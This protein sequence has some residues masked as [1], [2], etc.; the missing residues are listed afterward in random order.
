M[1]G[2]PAIQQEHQYVLGPEQPDE[3]PDSLVSNLLPVTSLPPFIY[4]DESSESSPTS[5][6]ERLHP[7]YPW[8]LSG[9]RLFTF[10]DPSSQRNPF[11]PVLTKR[12]QK[13]EKTADWLASDDRSASAIRLLNDALRSH[14]RSLQIWSMA[15][16]KEQFFFAIP[17]K[18]TRLFRWGKS[19]RTRTLAKMVVGST[20]D[21]FGVHHASRIRFINLGGT[22]FLLLQ[23]GWT[24]IFGILRWRFGRWSLCA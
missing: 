16:T 23:P 24:P 13:T 18:K 11:A 9:G 20:G 17:R 12:F 19:G 22:A 6:I 14:C 10:C 21:Q 15:G 7:R 8:W 2:G 5:I 4:S 1:R 3:V